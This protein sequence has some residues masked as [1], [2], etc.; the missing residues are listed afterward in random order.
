M[1]FAFSNGHLEYG[2]ILLE[3]SNINEVDGVGYTSLHLAAKNARYDCIKYLVENNANYDLLCKDG[4]T[5]LD[6]LKVRSIQVHR[7]YIEL[8]KIAKFDQIA[9]CAATAENEYIECVDN[10]M[11]ILPYEIMSFLF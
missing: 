11:V 3:F 1:H 7:K 8:I 4:K 6:L 10:F 9:M 5:P 2:K